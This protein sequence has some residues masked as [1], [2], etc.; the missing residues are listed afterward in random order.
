MKIEHDCPRCGNKF[1][2][3][4]Y[5]EGACPNCRLEFELEDDCE[6]RCLPVWEGSP[7]H[8]GYGGHS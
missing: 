4:Q 5:E 7:R 6:G 1:Q 3:E 8:S 2:Y